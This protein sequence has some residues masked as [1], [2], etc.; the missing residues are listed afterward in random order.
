MS[1]KYE[2]V[3]VGAGPAGLAAAAELSRN[4]VQ[5]LVLERGKRAGQKSITGG[6]LY[7]QTNTPYN[8]DYLY[9]D[10]QTTAPVERPIKKYEMVAL[11][12]DKAKTLD[13]RR[14]HE[15]EMKWSYS[16]LRNPFDAWF[17]EKVHAEARK[18]GGGV[19]TDVRVTDLIV[20]NG[21]VVGVKTNE[22]EDIRADLVVAADGATSELARKAGLRSWG[23]PGQ[24]FQGVKAV[25]KVKDMESRVG[26]GPGN[27]GLPGDGAALLYAGDVFGGVR[28]GGFLYTNK[29]TLSIGT[30]F[31]LDS[32]AQSRVEPH[33]LLD[34][35][36]THPAVANILGEDYEEL[37]YSAKL[38]PD[39]KKMGLK[40]PAV[41]GLV[42]VGDA[43][44]Q[45]Q[46]HGLVL[47]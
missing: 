30:V 31:H 32:L 24:W 39:G 22:L 18:A 33:R 40:S 36:L 16:V 19:L 7:G 28:G 41:P 23:K 38:I 15:H 6:I 5:T 43:A 27:G 13:L 46:A 4:G 37:E 25:V 26:V 2:A 17:A 35:L 47:K 12:G 34:R 45:M 3:V 10:F 20:E 42:A 8:L 44:R 21:R 9:P 29:D 1:E 11:A 14:L